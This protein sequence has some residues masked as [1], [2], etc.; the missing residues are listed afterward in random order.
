M[1]SFKIQQFMK[2]Y[3]IILVILVCLPINFLYSQQSLTGKVTAIRGTLGVIDIGQKDG[4]TEKDGLVVFRFENGKKVIIG[5]LRIVKLLDDRSGVKIYLSDENRLWQVDDLIEKSTLSPLQEIEQ[6]KQEP[7]IKPQ[8]RTEDFPLTG[9]KSKFIGIGLSAVIPG[10]GF[11]YNGNFKKGL[12]F[13]IGVPL[14][15]ALNGYMAYNGTVKG[16]WIANTSS[17]L[18]EFDKD[19]NENAKDKA[20]LSLGATFTLMKFL[21]IVLV[22]QDISNSNNT[23]IQLN[24]AFDGYKY[25]CVSISVKF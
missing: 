3:I 10:G 13:T 16:Q 18:L 11:Y 23:S 17:G 1:N 2:N 8:K 21:E 19:N 25:P 7:V 14:V 15:T 5:Q 12:L 24:S 9:K 22:S 6:K 20:I 4:L